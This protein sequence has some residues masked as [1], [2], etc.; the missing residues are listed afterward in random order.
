MASITVEYWC[1]EQSNTWAFRV[2]ALGITGGGDATRELAAAHCLDAVAYAL[3]F[4][5]D[6]EADPG[7]ERSTLDITVNPHAA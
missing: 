5:A 2:P 6:D 1:D 7:V 4:A 3:E